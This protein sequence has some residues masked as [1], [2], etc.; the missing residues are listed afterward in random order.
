MG[1]LIHRQDRRPAWTT[2]DAASVDFAETHG[3]EMRLVLVAIGVHAY[4]RGRR[5]ARRRRDAGRK[6]GEEMKYKDPGHTLYG[7]G[8]RCNS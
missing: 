1:A 6:G 3:G 7:R 5:E 8:T 2:S 4:A